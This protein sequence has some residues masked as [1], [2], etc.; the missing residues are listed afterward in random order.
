MNDPIIQ[1]NNLTKVYQIPKTNKGLIGHMKQL[2]RPSFEEKKAI[3]NLSFQVEKGEML[4]YIGPNGAGKSTTVKLLTGLLV[5]TEGEVRVFGVD[6]SKNRVKNARRTGVLMGQRSQ[7]W[8]DLPV[9]DSFEMLRMIYKIPQET[10]EQSLKTL[11]GVVEIEDLMNQPVRLLSLGQRM[12]AEMVATFLHQPEIVYL[13]EPTIGLDVITKQKILDF[14]LYVNEQY[15]TTILLTTHDLS[16]VEKVCQRMLL[17]DQGK[18]HYDGNITSFVKSFGTKRRLIVETGGQKPNLPEAFQF[19]ERHV[20]S[21]E[22]LYDSTRYHDKQV[23]EILAQA[24]DIRNVMFK[25][26]DLSLVIRLWHGMKETAY[27]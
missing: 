1:V 24:G 22:F 2:I 25:E 10:Y 4:A 21:W 11:V 8:W 7:L 27:A 6:A 9:R 20:S 3:E 5:P 19:I 26:P 14:L 13:D 18:L 16:D 12:R 23:F 17:I 15:R